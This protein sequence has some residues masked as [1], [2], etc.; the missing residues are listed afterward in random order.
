MRLRIWLGLLI[1]ASLLLTLVLH[2]PHAELVHAEDSRPRRTL[3][4]PPTAAIQPTIA[5]AAAE[6]SGRRDA[7]LRPADAEPPYVSNPIQTWGGGANPTI[8]PKFQFNRA[9][10]DKIP[11]DRAV[12]DTRPKACAARAA[13]RD[14]ASLPP[15]SVIIVE[16]NEATSTLK[17]TVTSVINRSPPPLLL[18]VLIVDDCSDWEVDGSVAAVAPEK[19]RVLRNQQHA[20][21]MVSR[22]RG[23]AASKAPTVTFLDAHCECGPDWLPP[24]LEAV[25]A[26]DRHVVAPVIDRISYRTFAYDEYSGAAQAGYFDWDLT[27]YWGSPRVKPPDGRPLESPMHAGGLF[28]ISRRWFDHLGQYDDG[29]KVWGSEN[30]ELSLKVWMCGGKLLVDPCSHVGHVF[31]EASPLQGKNFGQGNYQQRNKNR[32][33]KVWMDDYAKY[34]ARGGGEDYGDVSSR[35]ALR[36]RLQCHDFAWY[37]SHIY[38]EHALPDHPTAL[39]HAPSNLCIDTLGNDDKGGG[40]EL[41]LYPCH[42]QGGNQRFTISRAGEIQFSKR[43]GNRCIRAT[44]DGGVRLGACGHNGPDAATTWRRIGN[45]DALEL[46]VSGKCLHAETKGASSKK[47]TKT[48]KLVVSACCAHEGG[49]G[50]ECGAAAVKAAAGRWAWKCN[51]GDAA[52]PPLRAQLERVL[53]N[54]CVDSVA[55]P[56]G[57]AAAAWKCHGSG[58]NQEWIFEEV[59]GATLQF[60]GSDAAGRLRLHHFGLC[61]AGDGT[62]AKCGEKVEDPHLWERRGALLSA[63]G[64][65]LRAVA[66]GKCL[67]A[68]MAE[69]PLALAECDPAARQLRWT[70]RVDAPLCPDR[71]H[72]KNGN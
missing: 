19:V 25:A 42:G 59:A 48:P 45:G 46:G 2:G 15:T 68:P 8:D 7:Q 27:F 71:A 10:S 17:R 11:A 37:L 67:D 35:V 13:R 70:T 51:A 55:R 72:Q 56:A 22:M 60:E 4:T 3:P 32:L 5:S 26:D 18:E 34:V 31:R 44:D 24:L 54:V 47:Y 23:F 33:A 49:G 57:A 12:P 29:M 66:T 9:L 21:L 28:T 14:A 6:S 63:R 52:P 61:L 62:L 58:G 41:G 40:G 53:G 1:A 69:M 64:A 50:G 38:P 20:G 36:E 39:A 30:L 43:G 16:H 65:L